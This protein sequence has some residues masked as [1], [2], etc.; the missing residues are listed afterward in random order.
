MVRT[1]ADRI[2]TKAIGAKAPHKIASSKK[3][4]SSKAKSYSGGN[5][6]HPRDTPEWQKP[7]TNF[8]NQNVT[9]KP[10][11]S[12]PSKNNENEENDTNDTCIKI[13]T[14]DED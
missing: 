5:P 3:A 4:G 10:D 9:K 12:A 14:D 11:V 8:M 6:Y 2:P 1:K 13:D 7:I